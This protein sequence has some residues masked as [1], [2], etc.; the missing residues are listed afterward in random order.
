MADPAIDSTA[1]LLARRIRV[2]LGRE[3]GDLLLT[4]G[5]VVN[6]FT[7]AVVEADVIIADG[8]VAGVGRY[9]DWTAASTIDLAGRTVIPGLIDTHM[10]LEST[11]LTP[12]ELARVI[13]PLGTTAV[14]SD[15]HE[16]GNVLG[17]AGIDQLA[18]A[19]A[20]LPL[21]VF[22]MAS[23]CVPA[24]AFE[25]AG[26]AMGVAEVSALLARPDVLGLA[27][28]MDVPAVLNAEGDVLAKI[29]ATLGRGLAV[30]GHAPSLDPGG[31]W[32]T[33][34]PGFARTTSRRPRRKPGPRPR[35]GCSCRSGKGRPRRTSTPCCRSWRRARS[36]SRGA[37]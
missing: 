15:S 35:S 18:R 27:E 26:A 12:G 36:T 3:P 31:C 9:D 23:S 19:A 25:D 8:W 4:G 11:L 10:H 17:V 33:P 13:V 6:V 34:R 2:A 16:I 32:R 21:D 22:F 37:W 20:G 24:T 29:A 28:V 30:D 1:R 5:R 14:V 7:R